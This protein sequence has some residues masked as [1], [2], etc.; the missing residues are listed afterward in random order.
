[1]TLGRRCHASVLCSGFLELSELVLLS[2]VAAGLF[3]VFPWLLL[4][5]EGKQQH[6]YVHIFEELVFDLLCETVYVCCRV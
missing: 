3:V 6:W 5:I 2:M 1:M 4:N